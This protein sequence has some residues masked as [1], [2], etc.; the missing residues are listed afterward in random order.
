MMGLQHYMTFPS[1]SRLDSILFLTLPRY[2]PLVR[3]C[4]IVCG[5]GVLVVDF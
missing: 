2:K 4:L 1:N 3:R 5:R